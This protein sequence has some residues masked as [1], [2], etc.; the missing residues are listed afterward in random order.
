MTVT[1]VP[2]DE[3][4][5]AESWPA[6]AD[7]W[8]A[9][10][11]YWPADFD[12]APGYDE[13]GG[14]LAGRS[15][16]DGVFSVADVLLLFYLK[17]VIAD[18]AG[19][20][21]VSVAPAGDTAV[22]Q[23]KEATEWVAPDVAIEAAPIGPAAIA[24]P[25]DNYT[26]TQGPHGYSYG[27]MAIDIAAGKGAAVKSPIDGQVSNYY[28]DEWGNTTLVI[29]NGKYQVTMLHGNFSVAVGDNVRLGQQV[30]TEGNNGYTLDMYGNSCRNRDCGYHT[31]LN[32]FDK[33]L[34]TNVNP[35]NVLSS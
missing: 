18:V 33:E 1:Y 32:V 13:Y 31:H 14:P 16:I 21:T 3:Q 8:Q 24:Y 27:H 23:A 11:D 19:G 25:Y 30:G 7:D 9:G 34:G 29:D 5:M 6:E 22:E 10:A 20:A 12:Y 26:L 28:I 4:L 15:P 2:H 35:L 17:K